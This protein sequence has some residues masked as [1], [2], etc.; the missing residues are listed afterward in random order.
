MIISVTVQLLVLWERYDN[1]DELD[2]EVNG[3]NEMSPNIDGLA[4]TH[5]NGFSAELP[6]HLWMRSIPEHDVLAVVVVD[7]WTERV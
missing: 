3:W 4:M 2:E 7:H 5:E 1:H 6:A